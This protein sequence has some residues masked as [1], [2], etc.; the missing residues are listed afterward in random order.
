MNTVTNNVKKEAL[1]KVSYNEAIINMYIAEQKQKRVENKFRRSLISLA[2]IGIFAVMVLFG[3]YLL[4]QASIPAQ[5]PAIIYSDDA[6][7]NIE[8]IE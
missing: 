7:M 6:Q 5:Q 1:P 4:V 8:V 3:V 2:F